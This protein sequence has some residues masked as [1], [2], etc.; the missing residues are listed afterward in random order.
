MAGN[1]KIGGQF[2]GG[3][4]GGG[5]GTV[6]AGAGIAVTGGSTIA[7]GTIAANSLLGNGG[8]VA[9][10][11]A[12]IAIGAGL[13][14]TTGTISASA[15]GG[16]V[17]NTGT[18]VAGQAAEWTAATIIQGVSV[19]GTGNY[20]KA[21]SP[22]LVTPALGTPASGTLTNATGL[23][24]TTG[25]TGTLPVGSGG[26]GLTVGTSGGILAFTATG[27]L[28]STAI[29]ASSRLVVGGGVG[30][31]PHT[32]T[33]GG[34]TTQVLHGAVGDPTWSQVSL[35]ADVTGALPFANI[36]TLSASSLAGN[37]TGGGLAIASVPIG[38]GL[39]FTSGSLA[40]GGSGGTV[41][42]SGQTEIK[43]PTPVN[44]ADAATKAYVD[45]VAAGLN[46]AVAVQAATTAAG[47]TSG[48]TYNNGASGIGATLTGAVN[49]AFTVDGFTFSALGQR[50]LVK[51]DTQS[52]SGAFNGVYF[53]TQIQT[54]ILPVILTRALDYDQPSDINNT[55]SIPVVNG[56]ANGTTSWLL[57][58]AVATVGTDPLTYVL[59]TRN[60][61]N[62]VTSVIAQGGPF[63]A[64][65]TIT[66]TGTISNSSSSLTA[67]GIII[68]EGTGAAI[69]TAA[70]TNGQLLIGATGADPAPQTMSGDATINSGGTISVTK[71]S[72]N[73]PSANF[74]AV[75]NSGT[76]QVE[77]SVTLAGT[78]GS[79]L[80]ISP[81]SGTKVS[82]V[83]LAAGG[84]AQTIAYA[85]TYN[86]QS[87]RIHF[88]QGATISTVVLNTGTVGGFIF[89]TSGGPTSFTVTP[90]VGAIDEIAIEA[91][92]TA[93]ARVMAIAQGF[94]A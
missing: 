3:S 41:D 79:T 78:A 18:P 63:L 61:S 55:G 7:L 65:G 58:S 56:T 70:M 24:L 17:S 87:S 1:I 51:N 52:P 66:S 54:A 27:T 68:A 60:P 8:T 69:A 59:F 83:N 82:V 43:V 84:G 34:S 80:T 13:T 42:L 93:Y 14:V 77:Q 38:A 92:T 29:L 22:A 53:V 15:G 4:G 85:G 49:T 32:V 31:A 45:N 67:H 37:S 48:F 11:P 16:N 6:V 20:V 75:L 91:P 40:V 74:G 86:F 72:G 94:T 57:T 89:G 46:P 39:T 28:T 88:K 73:T 12:G 35:T 5:S 26:T 36:A 19:T 90:T 81:G 64:N 50:V 21:T 25:V 62:V 10:T 33:T 44:A 23:P 76:V 71:I 2:P 47:D 9:G 30:S